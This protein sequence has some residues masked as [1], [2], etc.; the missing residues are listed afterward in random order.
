MIQIPFLKL[1]FFSKMQEVN[2]FLFLQNLNSRVGGKKH[3]AIPRDRCSIPRRGAFL[4]FS[5]PTSFLRLLDQ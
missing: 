1:I 2:H 5:V 3:L 4:F